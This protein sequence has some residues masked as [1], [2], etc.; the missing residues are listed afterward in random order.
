M[1]AICPTCT[2]WMERT[3]GRSVTA[4][5]A[6]ALA[7]FVLLFPANL[8]PLM[9]VSVLGISRQGEIASGA[10]SLW[11][12]KWV[13]VA[14]L[15]ATF[16]VVLPFVRFGLLTIVLAHIR[17]GRHR[18]WLGRA[19][20]WSV[21]LDQWAMPDV[22]LIG[23]AIG[24]SRVAADLTVSIDA[25]GLCLLAAA[26][27][28]MLSRAILDR[29]TV[30][31]A[32][33]PER[34]APDPGQTAISCLVCEL[35]LPGE[36]EGS[37]CPRCQLR[38]ASRKPDAMIRTSAFLI[39][40]LALYFPANFYPM[41]IAMQAGRE[42]PH[43]IIDG[44]EDLFQAGFWPLGVIIFCTSIAIPLLKIL[45]LGW[46]LLSIR[47][48]SRRQLVF[49]TYFYRFIDEIGRWS[50]VDV[51]TIVVF[52]PLMQFGGLVNARA[53]SGVTAFMLVVTLTMFASRSFDPRLLWDAA[54][55]GAS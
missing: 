30:W 9:T 4:G 37:P 35:V 21:R 50:N 25:G 51:F 8:L 38:V 22:F 16:A 1:A 7:T 41:S 5:L 52:I 55:K 31:R 3:S 33:S 29:R 17:L 13:L 20:R 11:D 19:F 28:S 42:V 2:N 40:G 53:A 39:A 34:T 10:A 18:A 49:K 45:G 54:A 12:G 44:V 48:R 27:L 32:I 46:L 36:W 24:Y 14:G 26:L 6:C 47:R 43:R 15:V 23:F